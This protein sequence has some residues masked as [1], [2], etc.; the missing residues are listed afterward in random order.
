[1]RLVPGW[2]KTW[3]RKWSSWLAVLNSAVLTHLSAQSGMILG[4]VPFVAP[5]WKVPLLALTA[6]LAFLVP[7]LVANT[8]QPKLVKIREEHSA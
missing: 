4:F 2:R 8:A 1:M 3:W 6:V 5:E 7:V